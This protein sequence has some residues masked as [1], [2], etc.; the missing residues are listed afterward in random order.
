MQLYTT[1]H[2]QAP[3]RK[4]G[5]LLDGSCSRSYVNVSLQVSHNL[6][7]AKISSKSKRQGSVGIPSGHA[8]DI[9]EARVNVEATGSVDFTE[10]DSTSFLTASDVFAWPFEQV[11][12]DRSRVIV[13]DLSPHAA[14]LPG[15]AWGDNPFQA[16]VVPIFTEATALIPSAILVLGL[17]PRCDFNEAYEA[18]TQVVSR[19]TAFA[20][21]GVTVRRAYAVFNQHLN[22]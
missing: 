15:R 11:L 2:I 9:T 7:L 3:K 13:Q 12:S 19:H 1:E 6:P 20:L 21:L 18:F 14:K 10:S 16:V 17:N 8:F 4:H 5:V 22:S